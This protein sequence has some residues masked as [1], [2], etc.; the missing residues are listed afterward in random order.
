MHESLL[1]PLF[2]CSLITEIDFKLI[3]R[4]VKEGKVSISIEV[5]VMGIVDSLVL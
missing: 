3:V 5:D 2:T 4:K 1:S